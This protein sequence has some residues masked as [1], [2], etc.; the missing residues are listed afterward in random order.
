[1]N[2]SDNNANVSPMSSRIT[3]WIAL[4]IV[5][6]QILIAFVSY[7]FLPAQIP[8]H[9]NAAG[10]IDEYLPKAIGLAL[11]PVISI[12][13][14]FLVRF[15]VGLGPMLGKQNQRANM[16]IISIVLVGEVLLMLVLELVTIA[17]ALRL[18][19]NMNFIIC[20]ALSALFIF[21]GNYF[22]KFRRNF[23]AGIRTPWTLASDQVWERTHRI[24]GWLFVGMGLLGLLMSFIPFLQLWGLLGLLL[25]VIVFLFVYSYVIFH[26]LESSGANPFSSPFDE[27]R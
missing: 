15:L 26:R 9:W 17:A 16:Q 2:P 25:L 12:F 11:F 27:P 20:I 14:Y 18:A 19:V 1:M 5:V 6:L 7:P 13:I 24:G 3:T 22:G 23:W 8:S 4:S 10:E 21:I